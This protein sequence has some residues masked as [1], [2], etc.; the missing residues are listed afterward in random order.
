MDR[1]RSSP[2]NVRVLVRDRVEAVRAG[3]D[4]LLHARTA[5]SVSTFASASIW[6]RYSLPIRRAGSPVH[7][8]SLP[9]DREVDA[10]RLQQLRRRRARV[11]F[12][13][14]SIARRA[15]D[16][17]EVL[18]RLVERRPR[19]PH[20]QA[21]RPVTRA[22]R[23]HGLA[24]LLESAQRRLRPRPGSAPRSS[25]GSGA[26]RRCAR[27][28]LDEHRA[29]V[30]AGAA[31]HA[32]PDHVVGDGVRH[33]RRR[34]RPRRPGQQL[35]ALVEQV[36]AQVHDQQLRRQLLAGRLGGAARPGS[37]RTRCTLRCRPSASRSGR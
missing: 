8:S 2:P 3:R 18:R 6:K 20:V 9:E 32:V 19:A 23:A 31:R 13:R 17:V 11:T 1:P 30:H 24:A 14:S 26:C 29:L 37:G 28:V 21:V 22:C 36:V 27:D 10:G 35:R 4:D 15:A 34:R 5:F 25:P 7:V 12:A 33:Q 16:P